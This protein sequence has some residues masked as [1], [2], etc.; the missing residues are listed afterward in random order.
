MGTSFGTA[1][2]EA[3]IV[4]NRYIAHRLREAGYRD[5]KAAHHHVFSYIDPEGTSATQ[6]AERAL[7]TKQAIGLVVS[8]LERLGY[9]VRIVDPSDKRYRVVKLT[10]R[11]QAVKTRAEE[12]Y[13]ELLEQE[14]ASVGE[15]TLASA[16]AVIER[17][18]KDLRDRLETEEE[19]APPRT[20]V[21]SLS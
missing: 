12:I 5:I 20:R 13:A 19:P 15:D 11:G 8:E 21:E 3:S 9:V 10:M 1:V 4:C 2:R 16:Q 17:F 6:I 14:E 7:V 18:I